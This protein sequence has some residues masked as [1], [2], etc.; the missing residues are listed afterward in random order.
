M[1]MGRQNNV[2]QWKEEMQDEACSLYGMTG[3]FFSTDESHFIPYPREEDYNPSLLPPGIDEEDTDD[4]ASVDEVVVGPAVAPVEAPVLYPPAFL[5][6]LRANAFEGRRKL[7]E[8]QKV[9]EQKLFPLMWKRM[10]TASQS[11]V[12]EEPG[13]ESARMRLDSVKL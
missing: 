11:K 3:M 10:S 2:M 6:K 9:D 8:A 7:V 5:E 12:R 1:K 4:D 13:F